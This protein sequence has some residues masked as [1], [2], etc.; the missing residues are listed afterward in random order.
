M[1]E[2]ATVDTAEFV[3][4]V[5]E[6]PK[7][8]DKFTPVL[9][10]GGQGQEGFEPVVEKPL[11]EEAVLRAAPEEGWL[12]KAYR[13]FR[14]K[15][16]PIVGPTAE[17]QAQREYDKQGLAKNFPGIAA[18]AERTGSDVEK[19]GMSPA[20]FGI[21]TPWSLPTNDEPVRKMSNEYFEAL[22]APKDETDPKS[23]KVAK[24]LYTPIA[25][26]LNALTSPVSLGM[27]GIGAAGETVAKTSAEGAKL[28]KSLEGSVA[29]IFAADMG[30]GLAESAPDLVAKIKDPNADFQDKLQASVEFSLNAAF[31]GLAG[32]G[33]YKGLKP[34]ALIGKTQV[35][36][37]D[38]LSE[39]SGKPKEEVIKEV[40]G[41]FDELLKSQAD[42]EP[43]NATDTGVKP[44]WRYS[45]WDPKE[46]P[47]REPDVTRVIPGPERNAESRPLSAWLAE[48]HDIP[49]VPEGIEPRNY[50]AEE[51]R[52]MANPTEP[53]KE[54]ADIPAPEYTPVD[55]KE[56]PADLPPEPVMQ[57][58]QPMGITN[59]HVARFVDRV[60]KAGDFVK[61]LWS[62]ARQIPEF[63][64]FRKI[65]NEFNG[66]A[67]ISDMRLTEEIRDVLKAVPDKETREAMFAWREAGGDRALLDNWRARE[68]KL[69][70]KKVYEA[71]LKLTPEQQ[72]YADRIGAWFDN[73]FSEAVAGGVMDKKSF[74]KNFMPHDVDLGFVGG[75]EKSFV[76][77]GEGPG[78]GVGG[79]FKKDFSHAKRRVYDSI[80][81]L[82]QADHKVH[83]KD[84]ANAMATYAA[85]MNKAILTRRWLKSMTGKGAVTENGEPLTAGV[86]PTFSEGREGDANFID[87]PTSVTKEGVQYKTLDHPAFKKWY[88]ATTDAE[89][90][91]TFVKG[92]LGLHPDI[93][94]HV[95]NVLGKSL[96]REWYD[97]EGT[98]LKNLA[99]GSAKSLEEAQKF[100]KQ[101]MLGS[102]SSFHAVHEVKR[103][104]GNLVAP[105]E[106]KRVSPDDPN[107][108][109][110][111]R[112][113]LQ[114][115]GDAE[116][117]HLVEEGVG[118]GNY[119]LIEKLAN[120]KKIG[121]DVPIVRSATRS[122]ALIGEASKRISEFTFRE[123][124]PAYKLETWNQLYKKNLALFARD[125][126]TG[127]AT[128]EQVGY[129]TSKQVNA[130]FGHQNY[131]DI[132]R[133]PTFHHILSMVTL[134]PDFWISNLKNYAQVAQGLTGAKV[135]REPL[136]AFVVT[137]GVV[138]MVS[139]ILNKT[140]DDDYH[141][142]EPFSVVVGNRR[143]TMRNEAQDLAH[144]FKN[145]QGYVMGR[146]GPIASSIF[147]A[148]EQRN[149][150]GEKVNTADVLKE[151]ATK[152]IP[153]SLK[154]IPGFSDLADMG[155]QR[156]RTVTRLEE[157]LGSQGIQVSRHT[158]LTKAYELA[159]D[160]MKAQEGYKE[161]R[162]TYPTSKYQQLRY[163]LEDND[164]EKA[165]EEL[166]KLITAAGGKSGLVS[167]GFSQ[168]VR[169]PFTTSHVKDSEFKAS[170]SPED[171]EKVH[172]A[173]AHQAEIWQ[174]YRMLDR[175]GAPKEE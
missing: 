136:K 45:V 143:Y 152:A 81:D 162:G 144:L 41:N 50:T 126:A 76:G 52:E 123:L 38:L 92:E 57:G 173:E 134:A 56:A 151:A 149:W 60:V 73:K 130:R 139:R 170:L 54:I 88:W 78:S 102:L 59:P 137:A 128:K 89:G 154:W 106:L 110:A 17:Q 114:L 112:L 69:A 91:P 49:E 115:S 101:N 27:M 39:A 116:A 147:E 107:V 43:A 121:K 6:P 10:D 127:R 70:S 157:F 25:H 28:V 82:E 160:W 105:W 96:I 40:Q 66:E 61:Q 20:L 3:P 48:G 120:I 67:Q 19:K 111:T 108:R 36:K 97:R 100:V 72:R 150:R 168:S 119:N 74:R 63:G 99:A 164:L 35:E 12:H 113:G 174:R 5:T 30:R 103:G 109:L 85:E 22:L 2:P 51:L 8:A 21:K 58:G 155:Q 13:T 124:I 79:K 24:A 175:T 158:P 90:R 169:H 156:N 55:L 42:A 15:I 148:L 44:E 153:I 80:F 53:P 64:K 146:L 172:Q 167:K 165:Q 14:E 104:A 125:I 87:N 122:I 4:V 11:P 65:L 161:D 1:A 31:V 135:G 142:D 117:L 9:N 98:A 46:F 47:N 33:A 131:T 141:F 83:S 23:L 163:A 75:G 29:A 118:S 86:H 166:D 16:S 62:D 138:W 95:E 34:D 129:L 140:L 84:I 94:S 68:T 32:R 71:A 37:I 7:D 18:Q 133:D 93:Y 145:W 171:L 26:T 159:T 77:G 132:G